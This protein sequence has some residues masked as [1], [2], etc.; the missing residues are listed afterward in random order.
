MGNLSGLDVAIITVVG[1]LLLC[2]IVAFV[3]L[4]KVRADAYEGVIESKGSSESELSDGGTQTTY[5]VTVRL[6]DGNHKR[7]HINEK[8]WKEWTV[9]QAVVKRAGKMQPELA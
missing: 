1:A 3:V 9:G 8:R 2:A 7:V 6:A 4:R 5:F